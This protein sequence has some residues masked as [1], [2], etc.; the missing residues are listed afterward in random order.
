MPGISWLPKRRWLRAIGAPM[1]R[2]WQQHGADALVGVRGKS[3][4]T[5][6]SI[7]T[8]PAPSST[9]T[10]AG[11]SRCHRSLPNRESPHQLGSRFGRLG[12][13]VPGQPTFEGDRVPCQD[14][15]RSQGETRGRA[16]SSDPTVARPAPLRGT[17]SHSP[18]HP[19]SR[20]SGLRTGWIASFGRKQK[21]SP[22]S[23]TG[24]RW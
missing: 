14:S 5:S 7:A 18:S 16:T 20:S 10:S 9:R 23:S 15:N 17:I 11:E 12:G 4:E 8:A 1:G 24:T 19:A 22:A 6:P 21:H 3:S 2:V 13:T